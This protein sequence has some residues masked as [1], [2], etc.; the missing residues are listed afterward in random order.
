MVASG[1]HR[2]SIRLIKRARNK[3]GLWFA[4]QVDAN[5]EVSLHKDPILKVKG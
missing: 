4:S 5:C 3:F 2:F 1:G